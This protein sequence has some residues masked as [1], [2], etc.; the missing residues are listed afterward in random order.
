MISRALKYLLLLIILIFIT[1]C[2]DSNAFR[3]VSTLKGFGK[4]ML[5]RFIANGASSTDV[6]TAVKQLDAHATDNWTAVWTNI[7]QDYEQRGQK[8]VDDNNLD[9]AKYLLLKASVYY[10]I[11]GYP[12]PVDEPRQIASGKAVKIF[13]QYLKFLDNPPQLIT[14]S[15]ETRKVNGY[16]RKPAGAQKTP[17]VILLPGIDS[18]K[19]EMFWIEE[20]FLDKGFATYSVDIPGTGESD[21]SMRSDSERMLAKVIKYFQGDNSIYQDKIAVVGFNFGGYW[22]LKLAAQNIGIKC[23]AAVSPPIH[24]TFDRNHLNQMPR[25]LADMLLKIC[26]AT[27]YQDMFNIL[28]AMSL[29]DQDLLRDIKVPVMVIGSEEDFMVPKED[30]LLLPQELKEP[31]TL[32]IYKNQPFGIIENLQSEVYPMIADWVEDNFE[33]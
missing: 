8:N 7:A 15:L 30:L 11:A 18:N 3:S 13:R 6:A 12:Y 9:D 33:R 20:H 24:Y 26:G 27:D 16:Y 23:V 2:L 31:V 25:F 29:K 32:K 17:L 4:L 14:L 21:W 10:R 5:P 1:G 19:E 22:G 28:S